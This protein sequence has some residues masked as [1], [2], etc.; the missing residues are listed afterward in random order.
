MLRLKRTLV[1]RPNLTSICA[2]R[3]QLKYQ[4][5]RAKCS[6]YSQLQRRRQQRR[7]SQRLQ[8]DRRSSTQTRL[9]RQLTLTGKDHAEPNLEP[10][11]TYSKYSAKDILEVKFNSGFS[12]LIIFFRDH[13]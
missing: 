10:D 4:A 6:T 12:N 9:I 13:Q 1:V 5:H 11:H 3:V 7:F 2:R 8:L